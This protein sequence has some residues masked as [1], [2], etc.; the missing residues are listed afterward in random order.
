MNDLRIV[1]HV[2]L[3]AEYQFFISCF[4]EVLDLVN[5]TLLYLLPPLFNQVN[6]LILLALSRHLSKRRLLGDCHVQIRFK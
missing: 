1:L 3:L 2:L 6:H 4:Q 5:G